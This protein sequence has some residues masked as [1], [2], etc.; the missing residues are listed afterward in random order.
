[1][2][3]KWF[4][5]LLCITILV[6]TISCG[7]QQSSTQGTVATNT[8]NAQSTPEESDKDTITI[9]MTDVSSLDPMKNWQLPS[10]YFYWTVYERLFRLNFQTGEYEGELATSWEVAED[11]KTCT[12]HL[13]EGVKW[14]DGS[15]FT[16]KDVK[17]SIERS[18]ENG[19]GNHPNVDHVETP[20]DY[21]VVV[22]MAVPDS[23]FMDKQWTGDCCIMP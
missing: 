11:G 5:L 23:V 20:D 15:D 21:T 22:H 14:H 17:W 3:K 19:T 10:Y 1:M 2:R 6:T 7:N 18:I 9:A 12:F 4:V 8:D 13:R 16:S